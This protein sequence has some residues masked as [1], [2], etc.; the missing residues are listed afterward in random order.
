MGKIC[1]TCSSCSNCN[2]Y[3][4]DSNISALEIEKHFDKV[5]KLQA[6]V[7]GIKIRKRIFK[8]FKN[9]SYCLDKTKEQTSFIINKEKV[10]AFL[11][12][13][14][15]NSEYKEEFNNKN[16][17][18]IQKTVYKAYL[19]AFCRLESLREEVEDGNFDIDY[20]T[21]LIRE[22]ISNIKN[23]INNNNTKIENFGNLDKNQE[24]SIDS[25]LDTINLPNINNN[26]DLSYLFY[27]LS[28]TNSEIRL[29]SFDTTKKSSFFNIFFLFIYNHLSKVF[30]LGKDFNKLVS[31]YLSLYKAKLLKNKKEFSFNNDNQNIEKEINISIN[32]NNR[33]KIKLNNIINNS[34]IELQNTSNFSFPSITKE[35]HKNENSNVNNFINT[36]N[37]ILN[38]LIED[39]IINIEDGEF[40][41]DVFEKSYDIENYNCLDNNRD[42]KDNNENSTNSNKSPNKYNTHNLE[43]IKAN[44]TNSLKLVP[45]L[46]SSSL[47]VSNN[48]GKDYIIKYENYGKI[49]HFNVTT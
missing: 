34:D 13:Y 2:K 35:L 6:I 4:T 12:E 39:F 49:I 14:Q 9:R 26:V 17:F 5:I 8:I 30:S 32:S 44:S 36:T 23:K 11:S 1:S 15:I 27:L 48:R 10:N 16:L 38:K 43:I 40:S 22:V 46:K 7:R 24:I 33:S 21:K 41:N 3:E 31:F 20:E 28:N 25:S 47:L 45:K 42:N 29:S 18:K 37:E 19:N